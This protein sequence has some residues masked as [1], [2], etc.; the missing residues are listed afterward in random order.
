MN[1]K[2]CNANQN[3]LG[4]CQNGHFIEKSM[5]LYLI[6]FPKEHFSSPGTICEKLF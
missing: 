5:K 3:S 2:L 6:N 1:F 4:K